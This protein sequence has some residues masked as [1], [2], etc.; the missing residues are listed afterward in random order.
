MPALM[1]MFNPKL[2]LCE[3]ILTAEL[4]SFPIDAFLILADI[5]A[6]MFVAFLQL[7]CY[8]TLLALGKHVKVL[9]LTQQMMGKLPDVDVSVAFI[10]KD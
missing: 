4:T 2:I 3:Y 8:A 1:R 6:D 9:T 7:Q 10:A 5:P